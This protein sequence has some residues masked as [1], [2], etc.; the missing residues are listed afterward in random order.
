MSARCTGPCAQGRLPCTCTTGCAPRVIP[1]QPGLFY[2][3]WRWYIRSVHDR[4]ER[5]AILSRIVTLE[6]LQDSLR[7]SISESQAAMHDGRE[8]DAM[9]RIRRYGARL[10]ENRN[11]ILRLQ[12]K[13][14]ALGN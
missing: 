10:D 9:E 2:R 7:L 3:L 8:G 11:E 13:L 5:M 12:A 4:A 14:A 6:D 1:T